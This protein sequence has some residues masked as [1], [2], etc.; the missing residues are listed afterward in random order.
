MLDVGST[1]SCV[2][3]PSPT[4]VCNP[5]HAQQWGIN[6][7]L[8]RW[9]KIRQ[10]SASG[11]LPV[12]VPVCRCRDGGVHVSLPFLLQ[13][14]SLAEWLWFVNDPLL[15]WGPLDWE[16]RRGCLLALFQ[17]RLKDVHVL[18]PRGATNLWLHYLSETSREVFGK[19]K[20]V[21]TIVDPRIIKM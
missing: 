21:S 7:D 16:M 2:S 12:L 3:P 19:K 18:P 1:W 20:E 8:F 6:H 9:N 14:C 10:K 5:E 17:A 15:L 13:V 11:E 4:N